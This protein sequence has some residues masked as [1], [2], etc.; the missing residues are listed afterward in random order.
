MRLTCSA[1][2]CS[3]WRNSCGAVN[4]Y[5]HMVRM[6]HASAEPGTPKAPNRLPMSNIGSR[7]GV[8]FRQLG[9]QNVRATLPFVVAL[10]TGEWVFRNR[11]WEFKIL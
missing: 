11:H 7:L 8:P 4:T 5:V 1:Q 2:K 3:I 10:I 6:D 9:V